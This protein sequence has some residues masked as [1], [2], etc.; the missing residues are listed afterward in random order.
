M[1]TD[2]QGKKLFAE[3]SKFRPD[4]PEFLAADLGGSAVATA[5]LSMIRLQ[6]L[7]QTRTQLYRALLARVLVTQEA[8]GGWGDTLA[9][10]LAAR[11]LLN[12]A[13]G[14]S[15]G[16]K[17]VILLGKLQG[18][19]GT[20]P[21]ATTRRLAGDTLTTAFVLA[22]LGR[23]ADVAN[24]IRLEAAIGSLVTA[25]STAGP[26]LQPLLKLAISRASC[27]VGGQ[28]RGIVQLALAS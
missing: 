9:T 23:V 7:S 25:K 5:A 13:E 22:H 16:I 27:Q 21:R 19:D 4:V 1:W 6:E 20:F 15:A 2:G 24:R 11:A 10:V 14:R 17:A 18:G 8:D 12:D 3:L 28:A 26:L